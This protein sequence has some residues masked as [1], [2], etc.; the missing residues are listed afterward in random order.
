MRYL[1]LMAALAAAPAQAQD[2][3]V[4]VLTADAIEWLMRDYGEEPTVLMLRPSGSAILVVV[5]P[6]TQSWTI[7]V[8]QTPET[9]CI[10]AAGKGFAVLEPEIPAKGEPA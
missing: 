1:A 10:V 3:P 5:N 6:Q 9:S 2:Q 7:L 8:Q 4:C